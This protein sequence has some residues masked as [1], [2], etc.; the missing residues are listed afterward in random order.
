MTSEPIEVA[1]YLDLRDDGYGFLRVEGPLPSNDDVYVPVKMVR[2]YDLR[3]GDLVSGTARPANR[4]EKNPALAEVA[5]VNERTPD[6]IGD[7]PEFAK[8]TP[9]F[10][11]ERLRLERTDEPQTITPR[12][13]DLLAPL[14]KGQR[15]LIVT[16]PHSGKTTVLKDIA[17]SIEINHPEVELVVV[18]IDERPEEVTDMERHLEQGEVIASTFDRPTEEHCTVAELTL[19]RAERMV[20]EGKDVVIVLDGLTR[21][22]RAYNLSGSATGR[23]LPGGLDAGALYPVKHF[24]GAARALEEGG[25]LT[26]VATVA[27]ET[28][29]ELDDVVLA[30]LGGTANSEIRLDRLIA[31]RG[32]F[33][34]IDVAAVRPATPTVWSTSAPS[35]CCRT[36]GPPSPRSPD[37]MM[38][39]RGPYG[40]PTRHEPSSPG[41]PLRP[42]IKNF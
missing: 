41:S 33:P 3:K 36:C 31:E 10:P 13:I 25:S 24:F 1:G 16:P 40:P 22:A 20:E 39:P 7:R 15:L 30:E 8:L 18:M 19:A 21:L 26:I 9:I 17:R 42:T 29:S 23:E 5:S 37:P 14:G 27:A 38:P 11:G 12:V 4:N 34:A 2:Q 28:G 32:V 35:G 6:D